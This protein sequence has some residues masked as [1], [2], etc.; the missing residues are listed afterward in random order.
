[1]LNT[2]YVFYEDTIFWI[3]R[4]T[5]KIFMATLTA[6]NGVLAYTPQGLTAIRV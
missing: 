3:Q 2:K 6:M 4:E 1:M 5:I